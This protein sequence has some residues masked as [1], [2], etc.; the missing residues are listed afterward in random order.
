[1]QEPEMR[2]VA[3]WITEV[4]TRPTDDDLIARVRGGVRE[5]CEQFPVPADVA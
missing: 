3:R 1:M 5:L 4:L 2:Q